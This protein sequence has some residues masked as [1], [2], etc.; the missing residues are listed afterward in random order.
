MGLSISVALEWA[1]G[2]R[3]SITWRL[4]H[5]GEG[6]EMD[7]V[8][9]KQPISTPESFYVSLGAP[10]ADP[11]IRLDMGD[12]AIDPATQQLPLSCESWLGIQGFAAL[13]TEEGALVVASPDAPLVQPFG[14]Q[15][16]NAGAS[17]KGNDPSLAFWVMNNHWDTNFA[18]SQSGGI[19]MRFRLLPQ[20]ALDIHE[21]R[22]FAERTNTPPV[23]VRA[24]E[25]SPQEPRP[26]LS[27]TGSDRV[28][29]RVRKAWDANGI[30]VTLVNQG[31]D[32]ARLMVR[33]SEGGF[34]KAARA[35]L[36]IGDPELYARVRPA[37][38]EPDNWIVT[39]VN[40][41][42]TARNATLTVPGRTIARMTPVNA[43]EEPLGA[44]EATDGI[45]VPAGGTVNVQV[46]FAQG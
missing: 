21:A 6:I 39:L 22:A 3:A 24:Y 33:A 7:S 36:D 14:I 5:Q 18:L 15:T 38:E 31:D 8:F 12:H 16:Q 11:Q 23:I 25:S 26:L 20:K 28:T 35:V 2:E 29:A 1:H 40:A 19:P 45:T 10:G 43:L 42:D 30:V 46:I 32:E 34:T 4:P 13:G 9:H 37:R 44:A 27:V 41:T 17:R